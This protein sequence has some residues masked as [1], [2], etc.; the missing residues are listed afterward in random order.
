MHTI[1]IVDDDRS[2][3]LS[4]K[5]EL[6]G[7]LKDS[8]IFLTEHGAKACSYLASMQ[9]DLV[10]ADVAMPLPDGCD[11]LAHMAVYHPDV[12]AIAMCPPAPAKDAQNK[13]DAF[14]VAHIIRK[15]FAVSDLA[16]LVVQEL[17]SS[18]KGRLS[19][20]S[21]P[22]FM[23]LIEQE[24]R[25]CTLAV[26]YRR[27]SGYLYFRNGDLLDAET[28]SSSGM[29]AAFA[30]A[31]WGLSIISVAPR[32]Q[33]NTRVIQIPVSS[34]I[35]IRISLP[36]YATEKNNTS[37]NALTAH[38]YR[39]STDDRRSGRERRKVN[40][41]NINA[42]QHRSGK[43]RRFGDRRRRSGDHITRVG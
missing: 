26:K 14:A 41:T 15:P 23:Q 20:I 17:K 25:T 13:L 2:L 38:I 42:V 10:I 24:R 43:D 11:L 5:K 34:I 36:D 40:V 31:G 9:T 4:I 19:G 39:A 29:D 28:E 37:Q 3:L 30:M 6:K 1:L 35:N 7:R 33:K 27:E 8:H 18:S 32:C 16:S 21:L 12:P 22:S